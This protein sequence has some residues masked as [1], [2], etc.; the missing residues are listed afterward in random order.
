MLL[1][2]I[3]LEKV[4][5]KN[6]ILVDDSSSSYDIGVNIDVFPIDGLP[7]SEMRK[8]IHCHFVWFLQ[9]IATLKLMK[10]VRK[11]GMIKNIILA[12]LKFIF[13][14]FPLYT[15]L[16]AINNYAMKYSMEKSSEYLLEGA[17][18]NREVVCASIFQ[19]KMNVVFENESYSA[20]VGTNS[21]LMQLYGNY[22]EMPPV[23]R[24]ISTHNYKVL[25]K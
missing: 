2:L 25:Q 19:S 21:W 18:K 7:S 12:F 23:E 10:Y 11:R 5:D 8:R 20:P 24:R 1:I 4:L 14:P 13:I 9:N 22:M 15:V 3:I 17:Y 6:T 16:K